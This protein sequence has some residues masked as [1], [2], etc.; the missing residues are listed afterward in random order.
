[1]GKEH[2]VV[3]VG[4]PIQNRAFCVEEYL[5]CIYCLDYPR[6]KLIPSFFVNN[7][8]DNTS[9]LIKEWIEE[10]G[11]EYK[12]VIFFEK[13][14]VYKGKMDSQLRDTRDFTL[15]AV[16]RNLFI[17]EILRYD[18]DFLFSVDSD[19]MFPPHTLK[20]LLSH[21]KDIC[22]I[23]VWNGKTHYGADNYNYRKYM[24]N[25]YG[26][27]NY[28]LY[29]IQPSELFEVD[30]TGACYILRRD[31]LESG[32]KYQSHRYGEDWLFCLNAKEKGYKLFCDPTIKNFHKAKWG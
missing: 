25:K 22:S 4:C 17:K 12:D 20:Q 31:V 13:K 11:S 3:A 19:I 2:P 8:I 14:K 9:N 21:E 26:V 18:F 16:V 27:S 6:D 29:Q 15:F 24:E 1:M 10:H 5:D 23:M 7:S 32:I 28:Y 30:I